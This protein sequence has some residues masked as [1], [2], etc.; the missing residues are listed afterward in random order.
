MVGSCG[1]HGSG[2]ENIENNNKIAGLRW[3]W[4]LDEGLIWLGGESSL[5]YGLDEWRLAHGY[6]E[7]SQTNR[8][9]ADSAPAIQH[10]RS[11]KCFVFVE[12]VFLSENTGT[13]V[14]HPRYA[15]TPT[16]RTST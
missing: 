1:T 16:A 15:D 13:E 11:E 8:W 12:G 7:C 14:Y 5:C 6:G 3:G 9:K 4:V 10:L 2:D